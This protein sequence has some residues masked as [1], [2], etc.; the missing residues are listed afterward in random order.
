MKI[1]VN[2]TEYKNSEDATMWSRIGGYI[3]GYGFFVMLLL[4][5]IINGILKAIFPDRDLIV[6]VIV[7]A[8]AITIGIVVFCNR[9]EKKCLKRDMPKS[10]TIGNLTDEEKK[11]LLQKILENR[12]S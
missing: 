1:R 5:Y 7:L 3:A 4:G 10:I 6:V 12:K 11:E 9:M 8:I 2:Y